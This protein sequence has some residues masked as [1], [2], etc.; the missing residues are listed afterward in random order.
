MLARK[1]LVQ[2][3]IAD[4]WIAA[5]AVPAAGAAHGVADRQVQRLPAGARR[6]LGGEGGDAQGAPRR[7]VAGAADPRLARRHRRDAVRRR[8]SS[9][10]STW[11]SPT[12]PTEVHKVD[13]GPRGPQGV[14][15]RP[16]TCSRRGTCPGCGRRPRPA[17]P[18]SCEAVGDDPA[19]WSLHLR[20]LRPSS[21][22]L[23]GGGRRRFAV[24]LARRTRRAPLRL[25]YRT[26]RRARGPRVSPRPIIDPATQLLDPLIAL[27]A[28][29]GV[30]DRIQLAT[31][32]YILPLR[33]PLA[34]PA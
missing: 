2:A 17:S 9:S 19:H 4:S 6:H 34:S 22:E 10:R 7:R 28:R 23:A 3:M 21:C 14:S 1:Q 30:T 5:R 15:R 20:H 31:G 32:I 29:A 24:A 8:W 25:P 27:A 18:T 26:R 13:A 16:T 11:G 33:H 12:G